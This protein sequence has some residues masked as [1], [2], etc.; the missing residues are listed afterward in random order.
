M[1]PTIANA[2]RKNKS[3]LKIRTI[4]DKTQSYMQFGLRSNLALDETINPNSDSL[5]GYSRALKSALSFIEESY[6]NEICL[7]DIADAAG[8]SKF[9]LCRIFQNK[10]KL[11]PMKFLWMFR[12]CLAAHFIQGCDQLRIT[13]VAFACGF[14]SSAHFSRTFKDLYNL[15]PSQYR[16]VYTLTDSAKKSAKQDLMSLYEETAQHTQKV[17]KMMIAVEVK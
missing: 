12:S 6:S 17:I 14:T 13:D 8:V 16:K 10:F 2:S 7:E 3:N 1:Y 5:L 15:T 11:S 9:S 4:K